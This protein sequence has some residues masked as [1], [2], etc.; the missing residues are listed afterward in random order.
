MPQTTSSQQPSS[1]RQASSSWQLSV[2]EDFEDEGETVTH[3]LPKNPNHIIEAVDGSDDEPEDE[4]PKPTED[5]KE[6]QEED[7]LSE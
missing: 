6:E 5:D 2:D 1:S 4:V 7:E 3:M